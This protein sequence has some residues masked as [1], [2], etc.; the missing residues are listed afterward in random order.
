MNRNWLRKGQWV[1][2]AGRDCVIEDRL[3]SGDFQLKDAASGGC[4]ARSYE[5][6]V[7]ALFDGQLAISDNAAVPRGLTNKER[8]NELLIADF[9]QMPQP[10]RDE[11]KRQQDP[12]KEEAYSPR[13]SI[14]CLAQ[15]S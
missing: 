1:R 3:P 8:A 4:F 12:F 7:D 5:Q 9:S 6:L 14:G 10:R 13:E 11:A 15:A 2:L